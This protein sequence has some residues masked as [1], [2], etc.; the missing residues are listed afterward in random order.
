MAVFR[1]GSGG[2]EAPALVEDAEGETTF[3]RRVGHVSALKSPGL[4]EYLEENGVKSLVL[5]GL[6]TSGCVLRTASAGADAEFVVTVLEDGCADKHE[7]VHEALTKKVLPSRGHVYTSEAFR[8][9]WEDGS[10]GV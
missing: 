4:L 1:T 9:G 2:D 3:T 10:L 6:S 7:D 5:A 8:A